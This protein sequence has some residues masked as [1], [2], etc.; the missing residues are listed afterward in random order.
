MQLHLLSP[1]A[2]F[3]TFFAGNQRT[4]FI[5]SA[6][7]FIG[8]WWWL[9]HPNRAMF[10]LYLIVA[11]TIVTATVLVMQVASRYLFG[12]YPLLLMIAVVTADALVRAASEPFVGLGEARRRRWNI[13]TSLLLGLAFMVHLEPSKLLGSYTDRIN[14]EHRNAYQYIAE[15]RLPEDQILTVSP[16]AAAIVFGGVDYY[17]M[18]SSNFDEV[19]S[20]PKGVVDRWSGGRWISKIDQ[21]REV[22]LRHDRVW[23]MLDDLEA[24]KLSPETFEF[25]RTST[26]P[27]KELFGVSLRLWDRSRGLLA[28]FPEHGGESDSF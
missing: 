23:V 2:F 10:T 19:Y 12:I 3:N 11:L 7:F 5:Y 9:R 24:T 18:Q 8:C 25:L 26:V 20:S 27:V 4:H 15:H 17:L 1:P 21:I 6:L 22:M 14:L 28:Q 13:L 16:M